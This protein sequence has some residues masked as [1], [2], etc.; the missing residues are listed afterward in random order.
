MWTL[1]G[2][3]H[4]AALGYILAEE[5]GYTINLLMRFN[6]VDGI[7]RIEFTTSLQYE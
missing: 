4:P 3:K 1:D 5:L 7:P 2:D 6:L